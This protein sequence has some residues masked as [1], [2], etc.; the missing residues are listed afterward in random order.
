MRD[1]ETEHSR[2]RQLLDRLRQELESAESDLQGLR[3]RG[4]PTR[5]YAQH[6]PLHL[7]T[8]EQHAARTSRD[9]THLLYILHEAY[10][11]WLQGPIAGACCQ[12]ICVSPMGGRCLCWADD[13]LELICV[14]RV[15]AA[16]TGV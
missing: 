12:L 14:P 9:G 13:L 2:L 6:F 11:P 5:Q 8:P 15:L 3:S 10:M 7:W 1:E 16:R 4:A